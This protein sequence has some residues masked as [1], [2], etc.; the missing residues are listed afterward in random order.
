MFAAVVTDLAHPPRYLEVPDPA[1]SGPGQAVVEVLA[2]ALHPRVRSQADGS[3]YTETVPL[4]FVP[5]IDGVGRDA[6]GRL[7]YFVV[8]SGAM[9]ERAAIDLCASVPLSPAIDPVRVAAAMNPAMSS[10]IA[11]RRR[12]ALPLGAHVAILG[13]SG[14][15]G[16]LAIQ[17][18][19]H[20]GA[21]RI[22]AVAR[23]T[24]AFDALRTLGADDVVTFD[25]CSAVAGADVVL[26]YVWG[27]PAAGAMTEI[28]RARLDRGAPLSWIQIGSI[29]GPEAPIPSAALRA[30]G[31]QIIGSGQGSV[32]TREIVEELP[33]LAD[34]IMSGTPQVSPRAVPLR[35]VESEWSRPSSG[36]AR[37]VLVP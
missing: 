32:S 17:V 10:W 4:P 34:F 27:A 11:L 29:A 7:R 20:L 9:A 37:T 33:S 22:S 26:D 18:A 35:D 12:I 6:E 3:H 2:S 13:A 23:A 1:P 5:G 21:A 31:L 25:A 28:V 8:E 15:A 16:R 30:S 36:E 14:S 24:S 19:R